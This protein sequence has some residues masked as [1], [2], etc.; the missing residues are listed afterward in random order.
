MSKRPTTGGTPGLSRMRGLVGYLRDRPI[1][2]KLGL[3]MMV[4]TIATVFVGF[5]ALLANI[6][7]AHDADRARILAGLSGDAG[8]LVHDLQDE[9]AAATLMQSA[10]PGSDMQK[11]AATEYNSLFKASDQAAKEYTAHRAALTGLPAGFRGLLAKIDEGLTSLT[12]LRDQVSKGSGDAL[13]S[14]VTFQYTTVISSLLA[15]RDS[16]SQLAGDSA[17][18]YE[19]RAAAAISQVKEF[20]SLERIQVMQILTS[21]ELTPKAEHDFIGTL[22]GQE[23][24]L[25][26]FK[27]VATP[28]QKAMLDQMVS[29]PDLREAQI[30]QGEIV[31][32]A[33]NAPL[34]ASIF[35]ADQW[36]NAMVGWAN[37]LR[38]VEQKIDDET[39]TDATGLRNG[40][41]RQVLIEAGLLL[42]PGHDRGTDRVVRRPLDEPVAARTAARRAGRRPVRPA[43]G[44]RP[45]A[46]PGPVDPDVAAGRWRY[47]SPSPCRSAAG[48]SSGR[49]P[50]RS[51]RSTWRPYAP[52]PSRP[53]CAP[54]CRRCSS[55]WPAVRRSW[56]TG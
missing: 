10:P 23:Q 12:P 25:N 30:Y 34:P 7:T 21:R 48:T 45:A 31:S 2:V 43:A 39:V 1:W 40:V 3:I 32:L 28:A 47:R 17:L 42:G 26:A 35:T 5:G 49:S 56:S 55:T 46:R 38:Q 8:K 13:P 14:S 33:P 36:D 29:G 11:N 51:T 6:G 24:A 41:Q 18:S 44:R 9:R 20:Q 27:V 16:A 50:R 22:T 4:P 53:R 37:L 19:M 15:I 52:P 54:R